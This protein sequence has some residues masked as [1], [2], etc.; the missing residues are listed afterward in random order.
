MYSKVITGILRGIEGVLI[1]VEVDVDNGMPSFDMVGFLTAEVREAKERVRTA[2]KNVGYPLPLK[3]ITVNLYPGDLKKSGNGFDLPVAIGILTAQGI[4][5]EDWVAELFAIGEISLSGDVLPVNGVLSLVACAKEAGLKKCMIPRANLREASFIEGIELIPVEHLSQ[6]LSY[7]LE[8]KMPD[9][10]IIEETAEPEGYEVDFSDLQGQEFMKRSCE[11]AV[12]GMHNLLFIGPPG[13]GKTMLAK[14]IPSILP[15]MDLEEQLELSKIYSAAGL[16]KDKEKKMVLR[17]FRNPH[18]TISSQ[19]MVGGGRVP[20]PG[21]ISLAHHGVLFLDELT[22]FHSSTLEALRQPL[23]DREIHLVRVEGSFLYPASFQLVAA[24]NPCKCGYYPD[25]NRCRCTE[26]MLERY[27][28]KISQPLLDRMDICVEVKE[29]GYREL[30]SADKGETSDVIRERVRRVQ[31]LQRQRFAKEGIRFNSE[32]KGKLI[33]KY[34]A[35]YPED[36]AFMEEMYERLHLTARSYHK[37]LKVARTIAD[38]DGA[39]RITRKHLAEAVCYRPLDKKYW[40]NGY[41]V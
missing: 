33:K 19:G 14:C 29:V 26:N 22:E 28:G 35:L 13:A 27:I 40:E 1:R 4:I 32:M 17:P 8:K 7:F 16:L 9:C 21:E 15:E 3:R 30:Q 34:C 18:H 23:E 24:M 36:Q 41:E 12:S 11:V 38:M 10:G 37:I 2:L 31:E 25:R 39:E 20:K 5:K 6:M